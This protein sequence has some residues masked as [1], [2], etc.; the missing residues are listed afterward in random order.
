MYD[1]FGDGTDYDWALYDEEVCIYI[2][3]KRRMKLV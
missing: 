2:Y 1:I 3:H